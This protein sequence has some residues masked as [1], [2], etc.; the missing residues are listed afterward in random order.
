MDGNTPLHLA[1]MLGLVDCVELLVSVPGPLDQAACKNN[2]GQ[3]ALDLAVAEGAF[4][5]SKLY[6]FLRSSS[7]QTR[8]DAF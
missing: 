3:T 8:I 7:E 1:A 5:K 4:P 2:K 6:L